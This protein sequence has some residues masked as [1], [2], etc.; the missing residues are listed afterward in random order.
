VKVLNGDIFQSEAQTLVNTVNC[1]GIMGKGIAAEFKKRYPEMFKDYVARCERKSVK[2]GIPYLYK[3]TM[4]PPYVI[5]FPTKSHWR[6]A[7]QIQ[8][9]LDDEF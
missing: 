1:V 3:E 4:F 6:A 5:N 9:L 7:S 2:P 8:D